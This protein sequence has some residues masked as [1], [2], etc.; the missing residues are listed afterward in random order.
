MKQHIDS[1]RESP[2]PAN[3]QP[4]CQPPARWHTTAI[5]GIV[6]VMLLGSGLRLSNLG[7]SPPGLNQDEAINS[8]NAY[9]L[10]RTGKDQT[11]QHW[12]IFYS[13]GIGENRTTLAFY[14]WMPI[15]AIGGLNVITT[16]LP[17]AMAGIACLLI[18]H[19]VGNHLFGWPTGLIAAAILAV[20]PWHLQLSRWGHEANIGPTLGIAPLALLLWAGL[21]IV[22]LG[23]KKPWGLVRGGVAGLVSGIVSGLVCYGY[24]AVRLFVPGFLV[25]LMLA[26]WRQ[27]FESLRTHN[28]AITAAAFALGFGITFG[29]LAVRHMFDPQIGKRGQM[30]ALWQP[31]DPILVRASRVAERYAG[32]F[33]VDWLF[34]RGDHYDV[35]SPPGGGQFHWYLLPVMVVGAICCVRRVWNRLPE[36]VLAVWVLAYPF[37]DSL[38]QHES[39]HALRSAPG[40]CALVLLAAVGIVRSSMWLYR[41]PPVAMWTIGSAGLLAVVATN[42]WYFDTFFNQYNRQPKVYHHYHT[43]LLEACRWLQPKFESADAVFVTTRGMNQPFAVMLVGLGYE[44]STWFAEGWDVDTSGKWDIYTR[45]GKLYFM[46]NASVATKLE[47]LRDNGQQDRVIFIVRPGELGL[48]S[49]ALSVTNPDGVVTLWACEVTL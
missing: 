21:P 6:L 38:A 27:W 34:A 13:R 29:P 2:Q 46:Y 3:D 49:P 7:Q 42:A 18:L 45:C 25:L 39:M 44:P 5:V 16:R 8:W 41:K 24:P 19:Y 4:P 30:T 15:Q 28:G 14:L 26:T 48:S 43:D 9:C 1:S 11:G 12:P 10:L 20:N 32:H 22:K 33:G 40:L 47:K 31:E 35:Q 23:E 17:S 36:R 37:G